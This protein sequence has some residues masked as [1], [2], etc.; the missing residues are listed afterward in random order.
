[1]QIYPSPRIELNM[2]E[3]QRQIGNWWIAERLYK[4]FL[5]QTRPS[6]DSPIREGIVAR[7][8]D[9]RNRGGKL[10]IQGEL[11]GAKL[12]VNGTEIGGPPIGA[13]LVKPGS[14]R[15]E[16]SRP[17]SAPFSDEV[18]VREQASATVV[19]R[20]PGLEID[21]P[22]SDDSR[23]PPRKEPSLELQQP[24]ERPALGPLSEGA[25]VE[26]RP[27]ERSSILEKWWFWT[28]IGVAVTGAVVA[29]VAIS[30]SGSSDPSGSTR[31]SQ[32]QHY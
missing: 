21:D 28:A 9:M 23:E 16:A 13:L 19:V 11:S 20:L 18:D 29:G 1:M 12:L 31:F 24:A 6:Q 27:V 8:A 14:N 26:A 7:L 15:V 32:W 2:A 3:A 25:Q 30:Q 5:D 22:P 10:L 17:S 4:R